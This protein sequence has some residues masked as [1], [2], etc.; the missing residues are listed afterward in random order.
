MIS[1]NSRI[2]RPTRIRPLGLI[3]DTQGRPLNLRE[4]ALDS[5]SIP[6]TLP[7]VIVVAGTAMNAGKTTAAASLIKGLVRA[8]KRVGAVLSG[9]NTDFAWL[10]R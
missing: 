10:R 2:K 9:G 1:R 7:P 8:G 6:K 5:R 3:G 4:W